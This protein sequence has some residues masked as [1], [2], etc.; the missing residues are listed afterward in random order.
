M[1]LKAHLRWKR[2]VVLAGIAAP[3]QVSASQFL[4]AEP[5]FWIV[6]PPPVTVVND[7][8][9]GFRLLTPT[10][11]VALPKVTNVGR[12]VA[13]SR[14]A[15]PPAPRQ[16]PSAGPTP[17]AFAPPALVAAA[18]V[19][20]SPLGE[21]SALFPAEAAPPSSATVATPV[22]TGQKMQAGV[23]SSF[24]FPAETLFV[25]RH[26]SAARELL[27]GLSVSPGFILPFNSRTTGSGSTGDLIAGSPALTLDLRY[28]PVGYWF[29]QV[30]LLAYLQPSKRAP[31]NGDFYY[32]FGYDD[33]H[34]YTLSLIYSNYS[35]NR[36]SP[37]SGDPLT[38]IARGTISLGWK[39]PLPQGLANAVLFDDNLT[40]D[41]RVGLNASPRYDRRDGGV[42]EWKTSAN[43]GC[44]YPF[45]SRLFVDVNFFVYGR[46]QQPWDPDFTYSFGLA[47]YRSGHFSI[48]YANYSGNRFFGRT[49]ANNSGGFGDGGLFVTWNNSF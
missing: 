3:C 4:P 37:R 21:T 16:L 9:G 10:P 39:A 7:D 24:S 33:Y 49:T 8:N 48:V 46:G 44:R 34:P 25:R 47:D 17:A 23:K 29:A 28:Q 41:C 1:T 30:Q 35:N 26:E 27:D 32:S 18:P 5:H 13:V 20:S 45:T 43:L 38:R 19:V 11:A 42:G 14:P 15:A 40:I 6:E 12:T 36:F 2:L 22:T 31:W